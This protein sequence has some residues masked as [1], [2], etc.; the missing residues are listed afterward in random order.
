MENIKSLEQQKNK[1][2]R[3]WTNIVGFF[4]AFIPG[5]VACQVLQMILNTVKFDFEFLKNKIYFIAIAGL[6][7]FYLILKIA[8][9]CIKKKF[10]QPENQAKIK[11]T[12]HCDLKFWSKAF[13]FPTQ[14]IP[15]FITGQLFCIGIAFLEKDQSFL[16]DHTHQIFLGILVL[17]VIISC[18][19]S[20]IEKKLNKQERQKKKST[21]KDI[22]FSLI[23]FIT[24]SVPGA[25]AGILI[26]F[27]NCDFSFLEKRPQQIVVGVLA[28]LFM[29]I[30]LTIYLDEKYN[31]AEENMELLIDNKILLSKDN[32]VNSGSQKAI[33][34]E[35]CF[36]CS[37]IR[38]TLGWNPAEKYAFECDKEGKD[39]K[40]LNKIIP[41]ITIG[42]L[43]LNFTGRSNE[44]LNSNQVSKIIEILGNI[45]TQGQIIQ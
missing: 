10:F 20:F 14:F 4:G 5:I 28:L 29:I 38:V 42:D 18:I 30:K 21:W 44:E 24:L 40:Y 43:F 8:L 35:S 23:N 34:R 39:E 9:H 33:K 16:K 45:K 31:S 1:D 11:K 17:I 36:K 41:K 3:F 27:I 32:I 12:K 13:K 15:G 22:A 37:D 6:L 2:L 25:I 19:I 26:K 7:A